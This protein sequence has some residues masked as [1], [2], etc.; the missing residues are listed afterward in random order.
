M[1]VILQRDRAASDKVV[2]GKLIL[3]VQGAPD[4]YT[5]EPLNCIPAGTYELLGH[6]GEKKDVWELK[7]VPGRTA[8]LIHVGNYGCEVNLPDGSCHESNSLGCI[9][10][11]FGIEE[12][13]PMITNSGRAIEYLRNLWGVKDE[14]EPMNITIEVRD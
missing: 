1:N 11:G 8:I 3:P 7:D 10:V 5:L 9:L 6:Q 2:F 12:D 14:G 4:L 13:V